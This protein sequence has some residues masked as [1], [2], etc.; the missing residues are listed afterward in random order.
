MALFGHTVTLEG[1]NPCVEVIYDAPRGF[2]LE[3]LLRMGSHQ[4]PRTIIVTD[5]PGAAY[6]TLL[7]EW[8]P[9]AVVGLDADALQRALIVTGRGGRLADDPGVLSIREKEVLSMMLVGF[10]RHQ[11]ANFLGMSYKT[12]NAHLSLCHQ[13]LGVSSE[14]EL[15]R[16][17]FYP[18]Q[19]IAR[20]ALAP[21]PGAEGLRVWP[22]E[23]AAAEGMTAPH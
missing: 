16:L 20:E 11:V 10:T 8:R 19:V 23:Y 4:R 7:M 1:K 13:K 12:V 15:L 14:R 18:E 3:V 17:F 2:G 6:R 21:A 9:A 5:N 22:V